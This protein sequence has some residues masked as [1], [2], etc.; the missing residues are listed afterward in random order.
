MGTTLPPRDQGFFRIEKRKLWHTMN[1]NSA[2]ADKVIC[3]T[4]S[5][6]NTGYARLAFCHLNWQETWP[7]RHFIFTIHPY[8]KIKVIPFSFLEISLLLHSSLNASLCLVTILKHCFKASLSLSNLSLPHSKAALSWQDWGGWFKWL[9]DCPILPWA[10]FCDEG[11]EG[12]RHK[13]KAWLKNQKQ[14]QLKGDTDKQDIFASHRKIK[15]N[16]TGKENS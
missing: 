8:G 7:G 11:R 4:A 2:S 1:Y 5:D 10:S 15:Y 16:F 13:L 9:P 3:F 14:Y 12:V 6:P